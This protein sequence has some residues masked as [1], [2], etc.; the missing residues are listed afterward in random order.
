MS[1]TS[2]DQLRNKW[3]TEQAQREADA[4]DEFV[5]KFEKAV[6]DDKMHQFGG[7]IEIGEREPHYLTVQAIRKRM[8]NYGW[9]VEV[10]L[11]KVTTF[12]SSEHYSV[13][14]KYYYRVSELDSYEK[15]SNFLGI[16][17]V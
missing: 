4:V 8:L 17:S 3:R 14:K 16:L 5:K 13:K 6:E 7:T 15:F 10:K 2:P 1:I 9:R 11:K 12:A